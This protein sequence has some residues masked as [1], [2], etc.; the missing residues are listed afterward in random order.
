MSNNELIALYKQAY[1]SGS[2]DLRSA[3]KWLKELNV[4]VKF[5]AKS[6][7]IIKVEAA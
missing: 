6:V 1:E 5:I 2:I 3:N 7:I 4:G